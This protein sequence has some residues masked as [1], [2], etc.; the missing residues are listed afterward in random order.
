M[1][2][3]ITKWL[4]RCILALTVC[5]GYIAMA[6]MSMET[7]SRVVVLFKHGLKLKKIKAHLWK[8]DRILVSNLK[9]LKIFVDL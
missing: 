7:Q 2:S 3:L 5:K 1:C 6:R 8:K 4:S 9:T